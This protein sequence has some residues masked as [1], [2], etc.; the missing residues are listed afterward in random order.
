[1]TRFHRQRGAAAIEFGLLFLL[2]FTMFYALVSYGVA[3]MLQ[4]GFQHAAEE[5][6]RAAIAVDPLAYSSTDA[7]T[8]NGV[9]PRVRSTVGTS[10]WWLPSK[11]ATHALGTNNGNVQVSLVNNQLIVKVIYSNYT[12]DPMLPMLTL[13][14]IGTIPKLPANL[15]GAAMLEL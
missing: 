9:I 1:M 6:A 7:Y 5:G 15:S 14:V 10:L 11:A 12:S 8:N 2:F 13:P 3:M 4:E